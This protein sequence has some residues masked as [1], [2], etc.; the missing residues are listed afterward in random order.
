MIPLA[1]SFNTLIREATLQSTLRTVLE[2]DTVT[3]RHAQLVSIQFDWLTAPPSAT[4]LVRSPAQI[5]PNQV[6]LLEAFAHRKT[7]QRFHLIL[8]V[9][10]YQSVTSTPTATPSPN[11]TPSPPPTSSLY[12]PPPV[13]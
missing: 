9:T 11:P 5:T 12:I 3:F 10:P 6:S 4:I 7:G 2:R 8:D 13:R 1:I